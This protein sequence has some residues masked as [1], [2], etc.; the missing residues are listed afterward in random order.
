[1]STSSSAFILKLPVELH[2]EIL[3][4]LTVRDQIRAAKAYQYW[5]SLLLDFAT[6]RKTRYILDLKR[7]AEL[8]LGSHRLFSSHD[9]EA[10]RLRCVLKDWVIK[11]IY[12]GPEHETVKKALDPSDPERHKE[13]EYITDCPFLDEPIFSPSEFPLTAFKSQNDEEKD[14][15]EDPLTHAEGIPPFWDLMLQL[16]VVVVKGGFTPSGLPYPDDWEER[17]NTIREMLEAIAATLKKADSS[18]SWPLPREDTGPSGERVVELYFT[19]PTKPDDPH[20]EDIYNSM[21]RHDYIFSAALLDHRVRPR[22]P[23]DEKFLAQLR[24]ILNLLIH[25]WDANLELLAQKLQQLCNKYLQEQEAIRIENH[26]SQKLKASGGSYGHRDASDNQSLFGRAKRAITSSLFVSDKG[27]GEQIELTNDITSSS[28]N[29]TPPIS[30]ARPDSSKSQHCRPNLDEQSCQ[31]IV[32]NPSFNSEMRDDEYEVWLE[33]YFRKALPPSQTSGA[34]GVALHN[35]EFVKR[36][37]EGGEPAYPQIYLRFETLATSISV[38]ESVQS[39]MRNLLFL[40]KNNTIQSSEY[41]GTEIIPVPGTGFQDAWDREVLAEWW[42]G[43][44]LLWNERYLTDTIDFSAIGPSQGPELLVENLLE[45]NPLDSMPLGSEATVTRLAVGT[46]NVTTNVVRVGAD[47]SR[48]GAQVNAKFQTKVETKIEMKISEPS[49]AVPAPVQI[50]QPELPSESGELVSNATTLP[51]EAAAVSDKQ[52]AGSIGAAGASMSSEA[53]SLPVL[54]FVPLMPASSES[55]A[56]SMTAVSI[57]KAT[58]TDDLFGPPEESPIFLP[59]PKAP[60]SDRT[61]NF[62]QDT[63]CINDASSCK[64]EDSINPEPKPV[65]P[66]SSLERAKRDFP[67]PEDYPDDKQYKAKFNR[68]V[69]DYILSLKSADE[70][71]DRVIKSH[72]ANPS[73]IFVANSPEGRPLLNRLLVATHRAV[74]TYICSEN[75]IRYATGAAGQSEAENTLD[76]ELDSVQAA[77]AMLGPNPAAMAAATML[78]AGRVV[79]DSKESEAAVKQQREMTAIIRKLWYLHTET[80]AFLWFTKLESTGEYEFISPF[81]KYAWTLIRENSPSALERAG[82]LKTVSNDYFIYL[83]EQAL[84]VQ[85]LTKDLEVQA[86]AMLEAL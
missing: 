45:V 6:L 12:L 84:L 49:P 70:A 33:G 37:N 9:N 36:D 1:M 58:R 46:S 69:D 11:D 48:H 64:L 15:T 71:L 31:V 38:S 13:R 65:K 44:S 20:M 63:T 30:P 47:S 2:V 3:S 16:H 24:L 86:K 5:R 26:Y 42:R 54:E 18:W 59:Q 52:E 41:I 19:Y 81:H 40:S 66:L 4:R 10:G 79:Y 53:P 72:T 8:G 34:N 27:A 67:C 55:S 74:I 78:K 17:K 75:M 23:E 82:S 57:D 39:F 28:E 56:K 80:Y 68:A 50:A 7:D 21:M 62:I 61:P 51:Q 83:Q 76:A 32:V 43:A 85:S 22:G 73:F 60:T 77:L 29:I 14:Y 25:D 35:Y